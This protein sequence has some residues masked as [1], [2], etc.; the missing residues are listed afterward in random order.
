MKTSKVVLVKVRQDRQVYF[1]DCF[2]PQKGQQR[3][4][5]LVGATSRVHDDAF[6]PLRRVQQHHDA[7]GAA[8]V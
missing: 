1:A 5:P 7:V 6:S 3:R 8:Y 2:A 4:F